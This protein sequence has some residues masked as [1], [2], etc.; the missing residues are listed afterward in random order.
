MEIVVTVVAIL[1]LIMLGVLLIHSLNAQ[2][3]QRIAGF[4]YSEALPWVRRR[5]RR[6]RPPTGPARSP[7]STRDG[8]GGAE[9]D[10]R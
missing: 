7:G 4:H 2:H 5:N 10:S 1:A 6:N 3:D 8:D 9:E